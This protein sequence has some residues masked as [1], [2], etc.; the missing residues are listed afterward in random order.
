MLLDDYQVNNSDN[1]IYSK[2]DDGL[3]GVIIY[4]YADNMLILGTS[5][6]VVNETK[7]LLSSNFVMTLNFRGGKPLVLF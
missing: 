2:F 4:L 3:N 1:C 7:Q 6:E 5:I